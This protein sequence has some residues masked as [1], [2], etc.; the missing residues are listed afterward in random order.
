MPTTRPQ[1]MRGEDS[2]R[3]LVE[4]GGT[5]VQAL[6]GGRPGDLPNLIFDLRRWLDLE[7]DEPLNVEVRKLERNPD[8]LREIVD[9]VSRLLGAVADRRK[10]ETA[11]QA[12]GVILDGSKLG[13]DG[14]RALS[15]RDA[16]LNDAVIRLAL[17]DIYERASDATRIRRCREANCRSVFFAERISQIYCGRRC[18]N[19]AAGRSYRE[20]HTQDRR[21][22]EHERYKK[23]VRQKLGAAVRVSRRPR[24]LNGKPAMETS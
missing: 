17:D 18:A 6:K 14:S 22:R 23:T 19:T 2:L 9:A 5:N 3:W 24:R 12:G 8:G 21:D 20:K 11:Y 1:P 16:T 13:T 7:E 10:F 4:F 15:Y